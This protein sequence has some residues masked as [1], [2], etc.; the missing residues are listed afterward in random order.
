MNKLVLFTFL[1][2]AVGI[3]CSQQP[4]NNDA[5]GLRNPSANGA[6]PQTSTH[7]MT[8]C[9]QKGETAATFVLTDD[10]GLRIAEV[11]ETTPSLAPHV[12]HK[13]EIIGT[14]VPNPQVH[15]MKVSSIQMISPNCP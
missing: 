15:S 11:A 10:T 14:N 4:K 13:V 7:A 2:T 1:A 3:G 5:E 12:G 9:L 6:A 8:G